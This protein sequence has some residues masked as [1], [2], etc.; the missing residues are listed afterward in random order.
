MQSTNFELQLEECITTS[1]SHCT[2]TTT[3][4]AVTHCHWQA[5]SSTSSCTRLSS[6]SSTSSTSSTTTSTSSL[7]VWES[8]WSESLIE[9]PS[10]VQSCQCQWMMS[11]TVQTWS[12][13][14]SDDFHWRP[15]FVT[16]G[17]RDRRHAGGAKLSDWKWLPAA[18]P[19][20]LRVAGSDSDSEVPLE[21]RGLRSL[22]VSLSASLRLSASGS[23]RLPLL[24]KRALVSLP[25]GY[26]L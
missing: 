9:F 25:R 2:T 22:P 18:G 20:R 23:L 7:R 3:V 13:S 1:T 12:Y 24:H 4:T 10:Q 5:T 21:G 19:G 15:A 11:V 8:S 6:L 26:G 16:A 17:D 14:E